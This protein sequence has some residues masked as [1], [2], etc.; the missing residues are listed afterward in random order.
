MVSSGLTKEIKRFVRQF[1]YRLLPRNDKEKNKLGLILCPDPRVNMHLPSTPKSPKWLNFWTG[2]DVTPGRTQSSVALSHPASGS[3]YTECWQILHPHMET[4]LK[5]TYFCVFS[6]TV[7]LAPDLTVR[8]TRRLNFGDP[9]VQMS[10]ERKKKT[11]NFSTFACVLHVLFIALHPP[12][13]D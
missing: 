2:Y 9:K 3:L 7:E 1:L 4:C 10:G 8:H 13:R 5:Y 11:L 6:D 12:W